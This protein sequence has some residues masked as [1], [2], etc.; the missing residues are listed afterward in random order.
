MIILYDHIRRPVLFCQ[1]NVPP[2]LAASLVTRRTDVLFG[3]HLGG[4]SEYCHL[5][6]ID[7]SSLLTIRTVRA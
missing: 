6:M 3:L 5:V 2:Q 4:A 1:P 7:G